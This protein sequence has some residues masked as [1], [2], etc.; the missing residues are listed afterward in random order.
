MKFHIELA[1]LERTRRKHAWDNVSLFR[2]VNLVVHF[3]AD[4]RK[5]S[6]MTRESSGVDLIAPNTAELQRSECA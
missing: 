2:P 3:S 4:R 6:F 1:Y 5:A